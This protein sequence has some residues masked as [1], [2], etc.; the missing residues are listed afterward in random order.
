MRFI[1]QKHRA[2]LRADSVHVIDAVILFIRSR[3]LVLLDLVLVIGVYRC[4]G[5]QTNL[6]VVTHHL[7]VDIKLLFV[8]THQSAFSDEAL[9]VFL[10]LG[11][12]LRIVN[13]N[14]GIYIHFRF[15]DMQKT[16]RVVFCQLIGLF[17]IQDII[18]MCSNSSGQFFRGTQTAKRFNQTH[19][20]FHCS[21]Y[22]KIK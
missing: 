9:Q 3:E 19:E 1:G 18:G 22:L 17:P 13:I 15:I 10:T 8:V 6:F 11:I 2:Y 21:V 4:H 12:D 14:R 7:L 16:V 20:S 5:N